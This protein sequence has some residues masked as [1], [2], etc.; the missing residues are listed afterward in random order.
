M[1][2]TIDLFSCTIHFLFI[3]ES[4][5][6]IDS[7]CTK[8]FQSH[9]SDQDIL[10]SFLKLFYLL[11]L[12]FFQTPFVNLSVDMNF[13][14]IYTRSLLNNVLITCLKSHPVLLADNSCFI[15]SIVSFDMIG[16]FPLLGLSFNPFNPLSL[17]LVPFVSPAVSSKYFDNI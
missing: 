6:K 2:V 17:N 10:Y 4:F 9:L 1:T 5:T 12:P 14:V 3:C 13:M 11:E 7:S 8:I 16:G 15:F